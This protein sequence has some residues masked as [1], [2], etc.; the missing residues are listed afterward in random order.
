MANQVWK[1]N[2]EHKFQPSHPL[3]RIDNLNLP[4]LTH[5]TTN[6]STSN[7]TGNFD[8][9]FSRG[10]ALSSLMTKEMNSVTLSEMEQQKGQWFQDT[11][12]ERCDFSILDEEEFDLSCLEQ[13]KVLADDSI[14]GV[15]LRQDA[16]ER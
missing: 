13:E 11:I 5:Q 3:V 10:D 7:P 4:S 15:E 9:N 6:Q 8:A 14:N 16:E 1:K 2:R 12:N